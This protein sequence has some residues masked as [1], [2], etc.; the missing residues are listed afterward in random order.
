MDLAQ[1]RSYVTTLLHS[2]DHSLRSKLR[3]FARDHGVQL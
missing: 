2:P 1:V 3:D